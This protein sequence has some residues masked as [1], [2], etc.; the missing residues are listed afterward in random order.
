[1]GKFKDEHGESKLGRFIKEKGSNVLDLAGDLLPGGGALSVIKN[2]IDGDSSMTPEEKITAKELADQELS[3]FELEVK[4]KDSARSRE[5]ELSK[6]KG[7]DWLMYATGIVGLGAFCILIYAVIWIP[8]VN[9]NKMFVHLM[10][11]TEGVVV[12]SLFGYYFGTS[13]KD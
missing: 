10:G 8:T 5:V 3:F 9:E 2:L 1:M 12:T 11:M 13:K 7:V 6:T 4:D